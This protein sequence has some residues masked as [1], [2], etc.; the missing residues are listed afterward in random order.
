MDIDIEHIVK[1]FFEGKTKTVYRQIYREILAD[2]ISTLKKRHA[3][4]G[5]TWHLTMYSIATFMMVA[6]FD[7]N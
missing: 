1:P 3:A 7:M 6:S 4:F 2:Y 5:D